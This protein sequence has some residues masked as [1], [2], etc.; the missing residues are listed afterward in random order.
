LN[1]SSDTYDAQMLSDI[2]GE[3][4]RIDERHALQPHRHGWFVS[5]SANA[6]VGEASDR[7]AIA[8]VDTH[9][10]AISL[11]RPD[12]GDYAG[13]PVFVPGGAD[14]KEG[15]GWLLSVVYRGA[16]HRSDLV[17]LDALDVARGPV[18]AVHL[19]HHVPAGFHGNWYAAPRPA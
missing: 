4:P 15:E 5:G 10:G 3:F 16:G 6:N 17:V 13:E 8:H 1:G 2:Q 11:W 12:A 7:A 14:A 19:S 18:A 9:T